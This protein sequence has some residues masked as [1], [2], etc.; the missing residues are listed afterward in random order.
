[1]T[2]TSTFRSAGIYFGGH[3]RRPDSY[4]RLLPPQRP[5]S[6]VG[7]NGKSSACGKDQDFSG[8]GGQESAVLADPAMVGAL[9]LGADDDALI[10]A[11]LDIL[12]LQENALRVKGEDF[13]IRLRQL[14]DQI[15]RLRSAAFKG[16]LGVA[17]CVFAWAATV[18]RETHGLWARHSHSCRCLSSTLR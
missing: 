8:L 13:T 18:R 11:A 6:A 16:A 2:T 15:M 10:D 12:G 1:M 7:R 3:N 17:Q 9:H 5:P 14:R 4:A